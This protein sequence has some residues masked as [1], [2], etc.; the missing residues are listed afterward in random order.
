MSEWGNFVAKER[1]N[2]FN[3]EAP[4]RTTAIVVVMT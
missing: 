3:I 1:R 4:A 2:Q